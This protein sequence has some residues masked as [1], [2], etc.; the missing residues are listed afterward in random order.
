MR[1]TVPNLRTRTP[2]VLVRIIYRV[3]SAR[4]HADKQKKTPHPVKD[5]ACFV[6]RQDLPSRPLYS[7]YIGGSYR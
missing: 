5:G 6:S 7:V 1:L 2:H 3:F 4:Q